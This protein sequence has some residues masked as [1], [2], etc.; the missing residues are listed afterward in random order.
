MQANDELESFKA[1][2]S[3][4]PY[5]G[6]REAVVEIRTRPQMACLLAYTITMPAPDLYKFEF[7]IK[8]L[9]RADLVVGNN[10]SRKFVLVEFEDGNHDSLFRGG[11]SQYRHWSPRL[12][13]GFGQIIDWA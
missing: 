12:E 2:L 13:H 10:K 11:R 8:G 3:L 5:F 4:R 7:T 1:W 9:F 6:E